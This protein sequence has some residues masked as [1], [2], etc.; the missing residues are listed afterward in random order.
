MDHKYVAPLN[1]PFPVEGAEREAPVV[2]KENHQALYP[3]VAL[4]DLVLSMVRLMVMMYVDSIS[5]VSVQPV[6]AYERDLEVAPLIGLE[7]DVTQTDLVI[8]ENHATPVIRIPLRV[9][10]ILGIN[11]VMP[12]P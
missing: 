7:N 11:P 5:L 8:P 12:D 2:V 9:D 3:V 10:A 1:V 6:N 4:W